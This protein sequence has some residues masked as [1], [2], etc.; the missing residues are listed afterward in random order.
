MLAL[1]FDAFDHDADDAVLRTVA[2]YLNSF[3]R[4][5]DRRM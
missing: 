1:A 4:R 2:E 5:H 3:L